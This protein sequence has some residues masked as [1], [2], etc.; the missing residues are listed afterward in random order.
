MPKRK[1]KSSI[2]AKHIFHI[3]KKLLL[4]QRELA[5]ELGVS[6]DIVSSWE[7]GR[8]SVGMASEKKILEFCK[9]NGIKI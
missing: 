7:Q 8:R 3:R 5:E 6:Y 2:D 4:T 1:F 9:K